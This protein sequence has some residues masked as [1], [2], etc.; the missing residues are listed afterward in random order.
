MIP[1][2]TLGTSQSWQR[3]DVES[4]FY[5]G[6]PAGSAHPV[7][8]LRLKAYTRGQQ[9]VEYLT[10]FS[11]VSGQPRDGVGLGAR[12]LLRLV[13]TFTQAHAED[14]GTIG[15]GDLDGVALWELRTRLGALLD[16]A[17]PP[18]KRKLIDLNPRVWER[19]VDRDFGKIAAP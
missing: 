4:L 11:L 8:S 9:D 16:A 15:F 18:A 5:P 6:G 7:P 2:Q 1:W 13:S 12:Q 14:A 3:A 10:L 19:E 17:A